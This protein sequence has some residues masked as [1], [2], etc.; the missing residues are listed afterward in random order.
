M[1]LTT[2]QARLALEDDEVARLRDACDSR[3]DVVDGFVWLTVEGDRQDVVLGPGDSYV[4]DTGDLVT[5]SA[6][7]GAAAVEVHEHANAI[8]CTAG[9]DGRPSAAELRRASRPSRLREMLMRV[10]ISPVALA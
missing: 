5:V 6:L 7:R 9:R 1:L 10:S 8:R 3:L 2:G 4:V